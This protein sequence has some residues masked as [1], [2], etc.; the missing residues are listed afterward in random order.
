MR[1]QMKQTKQILKAASNGLFTN[2]SKIK[3]LKE[4]ERNVGHFLEDLHYVVEYDG[5]T[6]DVNA[7]TNELSGKRNWSFV[8]I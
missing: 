7:K 1:K 6:Y 3:I 2:Y 8:A 5:I 4:E